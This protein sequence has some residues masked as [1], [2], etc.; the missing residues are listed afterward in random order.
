MT[1]YEGRFE[2][3]S[4]FLGARAGV[5]QAADVV[6]LVLVGLLEPDQLLDGLRAEERGDRG[7][8]ILR[9]VE[10]RGPS[11]GRPS[12]RPRIAATEPRVEVGDRGG[13]LSASTFL[14]N[15]RNDCWSFGTSLFFSVVDAPIDCRSSAPTS[16]ESCWS[17]VWYCALVSGLLASSSPPPPPQPAAGDRVRR[18]ER[19][20][21]A[22][23]YRGDPTSVPPAAAARR[24]R[25][26]RCRMPRRAGSGS[27]TLSPASSIVSWSR[28]SGARG[29]RSITVAPARA[30]GIGTWTR[31]RRLPSVRAIRSYSSFQVTRSGPTRS[32]VRFAAAGRSIA[33]AKKRSD[34]LD[35]D[36][37]EPPLA[38][39]ED[40][41]DRRPADLPEEDRQDAAVATEDEA[42]PED[43]VL[44][45]RVADGLLH[46]PLR[47]V[48]RDERPRLLGDAERAHQHEAAH[49]RGLCRGDHVL[50]PAGHHPVEVRP[51]AGDD[52]DQVDDRLAALRGAAARSPRRSR[53]PARPRSPTPSASRPGR[54][55]GRGSGRRA[56]GRAARG[57]P[58]ARRTRCR[59]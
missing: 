25:S 23:R 21:S 12:A 10:C 14:A 41:R 48:V 3:P 7:G 50:R 35:P 45:A 2:R 58:S 49:A 27:P 38:A 37:L 4:V 47:L 52:R 31:P 26:A 46:R 53:R 43:H 51:A 30:S 17:L 36:R 56:P 16:F 54:A 20:P 24:A 13:G 5:Q 59:R 34:V 29:R 42:G 57:R 39:A 22:R 15:E 55:C 18:R 11:D 32:N 1:G 8:R 28:V 40:G 19:R 6:A 9:L 44:E 33:A